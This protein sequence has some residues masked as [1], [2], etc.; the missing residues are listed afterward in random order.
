MLCRFVGWSVC[1]S[2]KCKCPI[3]QHIIANR[4]R[5]EEGKEK[6]EKEGK[7]EEDEKEE[8]KKYWESEE[9]REGE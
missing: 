2:Q 3:F 8:E 9:Q 5:A 1:L 4:G 7:E 6:E